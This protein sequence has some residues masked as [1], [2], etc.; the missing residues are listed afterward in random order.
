MFWKIWLKY[1]KSLGELVFKMLLTLFRK[2]C[3]KLKTNPI[4]IVENLR[5][6]LLDRNIW[7]TSKF[8]IF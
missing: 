8:E 2:S 3:C 5:H 6:P 1:K 7:D 4:K